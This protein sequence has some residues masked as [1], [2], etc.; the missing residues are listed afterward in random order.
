MLEKLKL[1]FESGNDVPVSR[2]TVSREEFDELLKEIDVIKNQSNKEFI[3][4]CVYHEN[5]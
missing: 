1:K 4:Q 2:I 5:L 3:D